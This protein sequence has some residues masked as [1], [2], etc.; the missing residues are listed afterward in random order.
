[1]RRFGHKRRLR[2]STGRKAG[3]IEIDLGGSKR[4]RVDANVDA[5]ALGACLMSWAANDLDPSGVR[6]GL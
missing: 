3:M 4:V 1:M 5:D 6:F 2:R